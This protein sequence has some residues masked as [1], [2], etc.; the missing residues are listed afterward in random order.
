MKECILAVDDDASILELVS[1]VLAEQD[2]EVRTAAS[3][4]EA[5]ELL[6]REPFDLVLLDIMLGGVSGLEVCRRVRDKVSCPILFLSAK[7]DVKDIV[8]GLGLGAD[9]YMTKPF[10]LEELVARVRAHLRARARGQRPQQ[11]RQTVLQI[12][13]IRLDP[14]ERTVTKDGAPVDLSTREFDLL[15]YLM[16]NAGQTLSKEQIFHGVWET[17]YGDIGTVAINIKKLRT[18]IDPDWEYIKT[19]WGSGYRFVTKSGFS[20]RTGGGA[21]GH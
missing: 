21:G 9:D 10:A 11:E 17:D 3:G 19:I 13:Q 7:D 20:E 2:M 8:K 15:A 14:E 1:D 18:K 12:G 4:E 6:E 16:N 5:L